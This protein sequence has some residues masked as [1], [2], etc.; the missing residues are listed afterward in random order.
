MAAAMVE[1]ADFISLFDDLCDHMDNEVAD[2]MMAK[3]Q[4]KAARRIQ[5]LV[6]RR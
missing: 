6:D 3:A 1:N 2:E 4:A 5:A